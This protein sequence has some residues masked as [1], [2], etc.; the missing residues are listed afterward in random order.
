MRISTIT[1]AL[2]VMLLLAGTATADI[3]T[4]SFSYNVRPMGVDQID[5][6]LVSST[7]GATTPQSYDALYQ[8]I[9]LYNTYLTVSTWAYDYDYR[10][11]LTTTTT[12]PPP[13]AMRLTSNFSF[14]PLPPG[15]YFYIVYGGGYTYTWYPNP[16]T[17]YRRFNVVTYDY[18][19]GNAFLG[20]DIP[21]AGTF[22]M[23]VL[24]LALAATGVVL[25]RR[26]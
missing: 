23:I 8:F 20:V 18:A 14:S 1:P 5:A 24:G 21:T 9:I 16:T 22:G 7:S 13:Y 6:T 12:P 19:F 26:F 4:F 10:Y 11:N 17:G 25:L 15:N 3:G 2:L